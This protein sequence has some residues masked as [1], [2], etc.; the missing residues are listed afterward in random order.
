MT[1]FNAQKF[2][3]EAVESIVAQTYTHWELF[4]VDDG[5]ADGSTD[6][7]LRYARRYAGRVGYLEH[8]GHQNQGIS[9]SRNLGIA[10]AKGKYI[11]FLDADDVWLPQN[12]CTARYAGEA[13]YSD[14]RLFAE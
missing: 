9:A 6:I 10:N 7:A 1:F 12:R 3:E 14:H 4:L 2:I 11:A 8:E 5:S 13:A